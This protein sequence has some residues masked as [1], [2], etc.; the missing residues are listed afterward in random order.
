MEGELQRRKRGAGCCT[1][2]CPG[3]LDSAAKLR[4]TR[5]QAQVAAVEGREGGELRGESLGVGQRLTH[6]GGFGTRVCAHQHAPI[7]SDVTIGR[8]T[9][10]VIESQIIAVLPP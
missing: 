1:G 4:A 3:W 8:A 7:I 9:R 5:L 6:P 10:W 2:H